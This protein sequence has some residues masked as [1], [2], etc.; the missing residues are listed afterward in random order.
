MTSTP[1]TKLT[2]KLHTVMNFLV[3]NY[4]YEVINF[5]NVLPLSVSAVTD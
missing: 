5:Q 4:W 1:S 2:D 3:F